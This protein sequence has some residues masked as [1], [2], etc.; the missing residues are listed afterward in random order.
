MYAER[1]Q[2]KHILNSN[3][4]VIIITWNFTS[5]C[6]FN[7]EYCPG[8]LH[9]S[10]YGFPNYN[11]ALEFIK[12]VAIAHKKVYIE[13]LGG[14]PTL[15]PNL[16]NFMKEITLISNNIIVHIGTNGSRTSRWWQDFCNSGL[17]MNSFLVFSY[18]PES[19]DDDLYYNNLKIASENYLVVSSFMLDPRHI[20]KTKNLFEKVKLELAV[21]CFLKIIRPNFHSVDLDSRYTEKDLE[22]FKSNNHEFYYDGR[23]FN[24]KSN[25]IAEKLPGK[26]YLNG[27]KQNYRQMIIDK[28]HNFQG[29]KC[30]AGSKRLFIKPNGNVWACSGVVG[31]KDFYL[32]NINDSVT[33]YNNHV[34]CPVKYCSCMLDA[35]VEK[36][37]NE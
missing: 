9:D 7:C 24:K 8:E 16:I 17:E 6:N 32:G 1:H 10:K 12:N 35:I 11:K 13:L 5:T 2:M 23:K 3:P 19:I 4:D 27:Q 14:E 36:F 26:L 20:E 22:I 18:H 34:T 31:N 21:D 37:T 28:K 15:W 30:F 33:L 29:W 25:I